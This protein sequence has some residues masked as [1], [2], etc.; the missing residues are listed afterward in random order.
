M[1]SC[2]HI[3]SY[4]LLGG[5]CP[6]VLHA[7]SSIYATSSPGSNCNCCTTYGES[8]LGPHMY[9]HIYIS[10]TSYIELFI[11]VLGFICTLPVDPDAAPSP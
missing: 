1:S 5:R 7:W 4:L 9:W 2:P 11:R 10:W 8:V 6:A 3:L